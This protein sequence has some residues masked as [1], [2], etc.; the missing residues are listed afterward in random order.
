LMLMLMLM[1]YVTVCCYDNIDLLIGSV[2]DYRFVG[3]TVSTLPT[4]LL[5]L[6]VISLLNRY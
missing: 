6:T 2:V 3:S 1:S 4:V 5:I